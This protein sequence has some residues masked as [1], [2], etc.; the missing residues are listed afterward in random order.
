MRVRVTQCTQIYLELD[1]NLLWG[2]DVTMLLALMEALEAGREWNITK[3]TDMMIMEDVV[4]G[5]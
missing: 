4:V 3:V 2:L 5:I 1:I